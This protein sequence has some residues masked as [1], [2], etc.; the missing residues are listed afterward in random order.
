M[1]SLLTYTLLFLV[2]AIPSRSQ[3][4]SELIDDVSLTRMTTRVRQFSGEDSTMVNGNMVRILNRQNNTAGNDLA[5]DY[6]IERLSSFGLDV[7]DDNYSSNG[8]NIYA[9]QE[10]SLYPDSIYIVCGHYDSRANYCA[11][12]NASGTIA[13]LELAN[14]LSVYCLE[15]T[16]IYALWDEEEIGL[17]GA[18]NYATKAQSNGDNIVGVLNMDM[19]AWDDDNDTQFDI[20]TRSIHGSNAIATKLV[21]L[22]TTYSL[23]LIP[24]TINPGTSASDHS[25]FWQKGYAAVLLGEAWSTGDFNDYYHTSGDR[26]SEFNF[27]YFHEL[28]KLIMAWTATEAGLET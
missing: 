10:G 28:V 11:D 2:L 26:I 21:E 1:R 13:V 20:D 6:L 19:I 27:P 22:V 18:K 14:I 8:R 9:V 4:I 23:D 16:V 7:T 5:A 17:I 12:D 25:A 15:S 24:N 3:T